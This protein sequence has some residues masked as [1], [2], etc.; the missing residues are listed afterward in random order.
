ME[1]IE[2]QV[3][4]LVLPQV[5]LQVTEYGD[6]GSTTHVLLVHGF[7]DDQRMWEPVVA[8]LPQGWHLITYDVRGSGR[9]TH[10]QGRSSYRTELLVEDLVAV[11]D[12][13]VPAGERVHLV[14]HD[15]G[16][17]VGWDVVAAETW[18]PRL[19]GRLASY[20]SCSGPPLDLLGTSNATWGGRLQMLPQT[21]HSWYVWMFL[22]PWL[23]ERIWR[24]GQGLLRPAMS[25]L[26]PT[27]ADLPWG[28]EVEENTSHS[29][30]LYRANVLPRLRNPLPWRTSLPVQLVVAT[31]DGFVLPR[32]L[33]GLEARCRDLT[34]VEVDEGH[35]VPRARPEEFADLVAGFVR[36]H[37]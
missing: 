13:T 2:T 33:E 16:S 22:V 26:D 14:G 19:E 25:R 1:R 23:P 21:V 31:R 17:I 24:H 4:P 37:P 10:P 7:P 28:R 3:T 27:I 11:L 34:R 29:I 36:R 12:A 9:S 35:W 8:A 18:D 32:S 5:R 6:P 20:T 15:W 30:E